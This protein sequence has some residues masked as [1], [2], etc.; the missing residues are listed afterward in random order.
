MVKRLKEFASISGGF[1]VQDL[2]DVAIGN[3]KVEIYNQKSENYIAYDEYIGDV[4][5]D[6]PEIAVCEVVYLSARGNNR[7][8]LEVYSDYTEESKNWR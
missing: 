5:R 4:V 8:H 1:T 3:T 2:A 7:L 6:K